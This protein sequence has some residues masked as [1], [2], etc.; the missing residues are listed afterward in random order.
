MGDIRNKVAENTKLITFDLEDYYVSGKRIQVDISQWLDQGF[1]LR[2]KEFRAALDMHDWEQYQDCY[3]AVNCSTDAIIP[4]WAFM[5][6]TV[7]I[8][9]FAKK[10]IIGNLEDLETSLYEIA[11]MGIDVTAYQDKFV[12]I[13]GCANKPV[14]QSAYVN[15]TSKLI[16]VA[17]SVMYGEACSSVPLFRKK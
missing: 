14:P 8:T 5:L 12:I 7:K 4:A 16:T 6:F 1:I 15:I 17:K 9:S 13:K 3:V 11:I 10:V 2:E